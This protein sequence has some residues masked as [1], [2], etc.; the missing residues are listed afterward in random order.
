MTRGIVTGDVF[1]DELCIAG[2][3]M[4]VKAEPQYLWLMCL[5]GAP[6]DSSLVAEAAPLASAISG[7]LET[8]FCWGLAWAGAPLCPLA[9][10]SAGKR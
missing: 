3:L 4:G 10:H 1:A 7:A 6:L 5:H 2:L 9:A 8:R